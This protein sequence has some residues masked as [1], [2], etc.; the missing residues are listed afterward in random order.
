MLRNIFSLF[1]CLSAEVNKIIFN[2]KANNILKC[3]FYPGFAVVYK[4]YNCLN[5]V[6]LAI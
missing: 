3:F 5:V 2:I 4:K 6:F 1:Y